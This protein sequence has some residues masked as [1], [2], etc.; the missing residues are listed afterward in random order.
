MWWIETH[1]RLIRGV[2]QEQVRL[3]LLI[4]LKGIKGVKGIKYKNRISWIVPKW[5][6]E[7]HTRFIRQV[8][9]AQIR[10]NLLIGLKYIKGIKYKNHM[11]WIES[12]KV[13]NRKVDKMTPNIWSSCTLI[14]GQRHSLFYTNKVH[15]MGWSL[16]S[17]SIKLL[18]SSHFFS[19]RP[20]KKKKII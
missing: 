14:D 17:Y 4:G 19:V 3:N 20:F 18:I 5:W 9:Q 6:I 8:K 12:V 13:V 15:K 11:S 1:P 7:T 2:K 10:L 16:V